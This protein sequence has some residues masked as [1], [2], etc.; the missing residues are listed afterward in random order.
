[1]EQKMRGEINYNLQIDKTRFSHKGFVGFVIL[2]WD[3]GR[4][5][6]C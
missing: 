6:A 5:V 4:I 2:W 1:M 3:F